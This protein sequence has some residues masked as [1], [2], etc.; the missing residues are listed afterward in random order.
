M[1][2]NETIN[3]TFSELSTEKYRKFATKLIPNIDNVLGIRVPHLRELAKQIAS[4]P[5]WQT[6]IKTAEDTYMEHVMLQGLVISYAKISPE[7]RFKYLSDFVPKI[8]NWSVCDSVTMSLKFINKN[9]EAAWQFI[10]A[11]LCSDREYEIRF[12][13]VVLL[14]YFVEKDTLPP[15]FQLTNTIKHDAYYVRMAVA[16]LI[17]ECCVKCPEETLAYFRQNELHDWTHNKAIQKSIE[18]FRISDDVKQTLRTLKR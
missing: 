2:S 5:D 12:G 18:S 17:S 4:D 8:D 14:G 13:L 1:I 11:Y 7:L 6:W 16:W 15:I 9:K 3:R 10:Q